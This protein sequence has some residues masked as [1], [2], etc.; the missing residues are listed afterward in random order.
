MLFKTGIPRICSFETQVPCS[1]DSRN[2]YTLSLLA[3]F[4]QRVAVQ[5][6]QGLRTFTRSHPP[7][8]TNPLPSLTLFPFQA[9]TSTSPI[10]LRHGRL[11][12]AFLAQVAVVGGVGVEDG[13]GTALVH[14]QRLLVPARQ[15]CLDRRQRHRPSAPLGGEATLRVITCI[16]HRFMDGLW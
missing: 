12:A 14:P 16:M 9:P 4:L 5:D 1:Q 6:P 2:L 11:P 13:P 7:F 15:P 3:H 8:H 10:G